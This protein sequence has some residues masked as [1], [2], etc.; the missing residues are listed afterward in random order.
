MAVN[1][2]VLCNMPVPV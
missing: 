1:A 2:V